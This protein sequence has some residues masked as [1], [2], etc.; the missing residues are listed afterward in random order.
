MSTQH[1]RNQSIDGLR[2][3]CASSVLLFHAFGQISMFKN[4]DWSWHE[5]LS[6]FGVEVF[7]I[8]SGYLMLESARRHETAGRFV[9]A[10]IRRVYPTYMALQIIVFSIGYLTNGKGLG[11][12]IY[13]VERF[14]IDGL[15]L[16]GMLP[17]DP[18]QTVAWTLSYE[19]AFYLLVAGMRSRPDW[20]IAFV[21]VLISMFRT[22]FI[23]FALGI[24]LRS[25]NIEPPR[26][27]GWAPVAWIGTIS[28]SF[29]LWHPLVMHGL[30][31]IV[32]YPALY[33]VGACIVTTGV[34]W[35]SW[36]FIEVPGQRW[37]AL[38]T[39]AHQKSK[40]LESAI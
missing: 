13:F 15:M 39:P 34:A 11:D 40:S 24:A 33:L 35:A 21:C 36:K 14:V 32:E 27:L 16:P 1:F 2:G 8:I 25:R 17:I 23:F 31:K 4:Y 30:M 7:F 12:P 18:I 28:Y 29:Y 19:A 38:K 37:G 6:L 10:R 26:F 22:E 5:P 20:A 3:L 9:L